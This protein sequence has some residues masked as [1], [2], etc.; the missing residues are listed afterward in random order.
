MS[1][2]QRGSWSTQDPQASRWSSSR[3]QPA[4]L[5]GHEE[6]ERRSSAPSSRGASNT[7][8]GAFTKISDISREQMQNPLGILGNSN[9]ALPMRPMSTNIEHYNV[10]RKKLDQEL[11]TRSTP[12][13]LLLQKHLL[14]MKKT[15]AYIARGSLTA[16]RLDIN[17]RGYYDGSPGSGT[18][19]I[20]YD[21]VSPFADMGNIDITATEAKERK[22]D[23]G[24]LYIRHHS[25]PHALSEHRL[26]LPAKVAE[27][28][29]DLEKVPKYHSYTTLRNNI[30]S[31][32]DEIMRYYPYLGDEAGD[33]EI[34]QLSAEETFIDRTRATAEE[35]KKD[36]CMTPPD[37]S[38]APC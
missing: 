38:I 1:S 21:E 20:S 33:D 24:R 19:G 11:E 13:K 22:I 3:P 5:P 25:K 35:G 14:Q 26:V 4:T 36:E 37:R 10:L 18:P 16:A 6:E 8:K 34:N 32:D 15:H 12:Y 2:F 27:T 17:A 31:D 7:H 30:L 9:A 23:V 28:P 29:K